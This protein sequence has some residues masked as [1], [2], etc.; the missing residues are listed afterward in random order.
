MF[1]VIYTDL[2]VIICDLPTNIKYDLYIYVQW[3]YMLSTAT[4]LP[5]I[6][7][8]VDI[9]QIK[10]VFLYFANNYGQRHEYKSLNQLNSF[11]KHSYLYPPRL[12]F[13]NF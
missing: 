5:I 7:C 3:Y 2:V 10:K 9:K 1:Y 8:F 11:L 13:L 12:M 6:Y 4:L